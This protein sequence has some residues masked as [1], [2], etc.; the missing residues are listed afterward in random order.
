MHDEEDEDEEEEEEEEEEGDREVENT[1]NCFA[2]SPSQTK[3]QLWN[4]DTDISGS[5]GGACRKIYARP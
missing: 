4:G 3:C 2:A 1:R 5:G